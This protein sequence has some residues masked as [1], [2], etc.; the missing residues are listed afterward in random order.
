MPTTRV[1]ETSQGEE[2]DGVCLLHDKVGNLPRDFPSILRNPGKDMDKQRV[3]EH[4]QLFHEFERLTT[5]P[6]Q[7]LGLLEDTLHEHGDEAHFESRRLLC[8]LFQVHIEDIIIA[9][10]ICS[11]TIIQSLLY[12]IPMINARKLLSITYLRNLGHFMQCCQQRQKWR[13]PV[14]IMCYSF[15]HLV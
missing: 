4:D 5:D 11:L 7:L 6:D 14:E 13:M 2:A 12:R 3:V 9:H 10:Y 15:M 1:C 8:A